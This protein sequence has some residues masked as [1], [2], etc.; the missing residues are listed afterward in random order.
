MSRNVSLVVNI[1]STKEYENISIYIGYVAYV[2]ITEI[3]RTVE[4]LNLNV[5]QN[6]T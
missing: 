4:Y 5:A 1:L 2:L 3:F 6:C